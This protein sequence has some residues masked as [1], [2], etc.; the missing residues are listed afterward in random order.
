VASA[1]VGA[2]LGAIGLSAAL[3]WLHVRERSIWPV[4]VVHGLSSGFAYLLVPLLF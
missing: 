3:V 1:V 2:A 4:V